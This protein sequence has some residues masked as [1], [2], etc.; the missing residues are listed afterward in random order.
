M[1]NLSF[2]AADRKSVG[3]IRF[4]CLTQSEATRCCATESCGVIL[5]CVSA[6]I[7]C[8]KWS[9]WP[10]WSMPLQIRIS[11]LRQGQTAGFKLRRESCGGQHFKGLYHNLWH[12]IIGAPKTSGDL[13]V[14]FFLFYSC[15]PA[16]ACVMQE[17]F[18]KSDVI[19]DI[20]GKIKEE[21]RMPFFFS[22]SIF[23]IKTSNILYNCCW[24]I[25]QD[26]YTRCL[27]NYTSFQHSRICWCAEFK[28]K[29]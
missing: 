10:L 17:G 24:A 29:P 15:C 4:L 1:W 19:F 12:V 18:Q 2:K 14:F 7:T 25:I 9:C 27:Y 16:L 23:P 3:G 11:G 6:L 13:M 28:M 26:I 8:L 5:I 20:G 21:E 22:G